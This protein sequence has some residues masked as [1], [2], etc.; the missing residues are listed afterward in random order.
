MGVG[1]VGLAS[2]YDVHGAGSTLSQLH[3]LVQQCWNAMHQRDK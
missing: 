2:T 3:V 1:L